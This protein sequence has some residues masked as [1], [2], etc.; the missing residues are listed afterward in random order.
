VTALGY[1]K[2]IQ[3]F[4]GLNGLE[5]FGCRLIKRGDLSDRPILLYEEP[6]RTL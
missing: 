5:E 3:F 4:G 6:L 1:F 2:T